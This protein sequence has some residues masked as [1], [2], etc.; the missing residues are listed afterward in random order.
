MTYE[1][2]GAWGIIF[3]TDHQGAN[4][5]TE[6]MFTALERFSKGTLM[7]A[8]NGNDYG[9]SELG[10]LYNM[11]TIFE[12][13]PLTDSVKVLH[14]FD[15]TNTGSY[16]KGDLLQASNG[17]L[18]GMTNQGG[19]ENN[20]GVV[21]EFDLSVMTFTKIYDFGEYPKG[22]LPHGSLIQAT[23]GKL[24]GM[25]Q[26]G[27]TAGGNGTVFEIDLS[28]PT[29]T[30]LYSFSG[31]SSDGSKPLGKLL[32]V[33]DSLLYGLTPEGGASNQGTLFK[34]NIDNATHTKLQDFSES[35]TGG[36]PKGSLIQA[37][38][39]KLFGL[40]TDGYCCGGVFEYDRINN[41]LTQKYDFTLD[42][43]AGPI[44][45]NLVEGETDVFFGLTNRRG[46]YDDG[47]IFRYNNSSDEYTTLYDFDLNESYDEN[48]YGSLV[49]DAPG[50]FLFMTR[51]GGTAGVGT[52]SEWDTVTD[53]YSI[54][55]SF[56]SYS[57]GVK[58]TGSLLAASNGK[59][60]GV[61]LFGGAY[62]LGALFEYDPFTGDYT[63]H[64]DFDGATTGAYP[65]SS[66]IEATNG[67]FYGVTT[68][69]GANGGSFLGGVLFE[70]DPQANT[71]A[72]VHHF[73]SA[74]GE[75]PIGGPVQ[76]SN[77]KLYGMTSYGGAHFNHGVL[78]EYDPSTSTYTAKHHFNNNANADGRS[79]EGCL[80]ETNTDTLYGM[81]TSGGTNN[82]G[83]IFEYIISTNT[84]T[85]KHDFVS[86]SGMEPKG[87][88]YKA[89]NGKLYGTTNNGGANFQGTVFEYDITS[90]VFTLVHSFQE[91][92]TG[93]NPYNT[94]VESSDGHLYGMT[95]GDTDPG[96]KGTFFRV[97]ISTNTV[98]K[99][100]DFNGTNGSKP[101]YTQLL[102]VLVHA[103]WTGAV[104][105]DWHDP[106]NW[107]QNDVP[108]VFTEVSIPDVS[109]SSGNF[110]VISSDVYVRDLEVQN[111]ATIIV[112]N[113]AEVKVG[114]NPN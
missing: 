96:H 87:S 45:T 47:V 9:M 72:V 26:L 60:Y 69:W 14:H 99:V 66:L 112:Q 2:G 21:F 12:Y 84:L 78:Y 56:D 34:Y 92:S 71:L 33:S 94:L 37:S 55:Y 57:G 103:D 20:R 53:A 43:G 100:F 101:Q 111:G 76:A 11:G 52:I 46:A 44:Y 36:N 1:G 83:T 109:G 32:Q 113:G 39:G 54:R 8:F 59:F 91:A 61:T 29:L 89:S 106:A 58:P 107:A 102:K 35:T 81:T 110:P 42:D 114:A 31:A 62:N 7:Q 74:T 93:K 6:Y 63:N 97:N 48:V 38:N 88:L 70:F 104:S 80:I 75:R 105:T 82:I 85:K 40:Y 19:N 65:N 18:Y 64:H 73:T 49:E 30:R 86:S 50:K 51:I 16:P 10:G 79:P 3:K 25:T 13:D 27:G 41:T 15:G 95:C 90:G 77:G 108:T 98:T 28:G 17:K 68:T 23:N 5:S 22:R 4:F 24:Y 67:K